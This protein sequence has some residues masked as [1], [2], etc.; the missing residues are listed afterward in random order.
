MWLIQNPALYRVGLYQAITP[1]IYFAH[2]RQTTIN[3]SSYRSYIYKA[4]KHT[5]LYS[6]KKAQLFPLVPGHTLNPHDKPLCLPDGQ[7]LAHFRSA[8][9]PINHFR[10]TTVSF[11][12][13]CRRGQ[14]YGL[15][16]SYFHF[17]GFLKVNSALNLIFW[18]GIQD[19][20]APKFTMRIFWLR[21]P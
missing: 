11:G 8:A 9:P 17:K 13:F 4:E 15:L 7:W 18:V 19:G 14:I 12:I 6:M 5:N 20:D 16:G 1:I 3:H 21:I 2:H 10:W